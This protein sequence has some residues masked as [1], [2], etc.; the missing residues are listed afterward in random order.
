MIRHPRWN[1]E[2]FTGLEF[3][4]ILVMIIV[5]AIIPLAFLNGGDIT[6][7]RRTFPGGLV[8]ESM[9]ISGDNIQPVGNV[10]AFPSISR[11]SG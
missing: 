9:Y 10:Y 3:I 2:A 7:S 5:V 1:D 4:I 8:A 6:G 11:I